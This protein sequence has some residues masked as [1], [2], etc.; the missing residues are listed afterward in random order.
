MT[1]SVA[2]IIKKSD[3]YLL[4]KRK[5]GGSIGGKWEFP[6]GKVKQNENHDQALK[7]EFIEELNTEIK[8]KQFITKKYFSADNHSF[9]LF[10]YYVELV[11]EDI[12]YNEH[13]E[14]KW[15]TINEIIR[16][17]TLLADSDR[18]LLNEL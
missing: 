13:V 17:G 11:S 8:V 3:K 4:G 2:G 6:G 15:F 9:N 5:P 16:L 1:E 14:F 10:A 7:R 18:L 12:S